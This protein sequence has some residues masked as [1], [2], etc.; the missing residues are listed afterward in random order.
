MSGSYRFNHAENSWYNV[1]KLHLPDHDY[2]NKANS[3]YSQSDPGVK[4]GERKDGMVSGGL[5]YYDNATYSGPHTNKGSFAR[6][7]DEHSD[8]TYRKKRSR[9]LLA[10]IIIVLL[11]VIGIAVFL[12]IYFGIM[13]KPDTV[14]K[15]SQYEKGKFQTSM[16]INKPYD[17]AY[18]NQNSQQ[19]KDMKA[20][21]EGQLASMYQGSALKNDFQGVTVTGLSQGSIVADYIITLNP[22]TVQTVST[23]QQATEQSVQQIKADSSSS[24]DLMKAVDQVTVTVVVVSQTTTTTTPTTT[25][26]KATTTL[27]VTTEGAQPTTTTIKAP[28]TTT[29]KA[30]T[31]E[32]LT[33]EDAQPSM[34]TTKAPTTTT[35]KTTTTEVL[36]TEGD[37]PST[38]TSKTPTTTTTEATTEEV[39]TTEDNKIPMTTT[40]IT[41]TTGTTK[42]AITEAETTKQIT[43]QQSTQS[44]VTEAKKTTQSVVTQEQT[45][46]ENL[47]TQEHTTAENIITQD[48]TTTQYVVT[49][50][51]TTAE[52]VITQD[53]TTTQYVV[54]PEQTTAENVITQDKTTTQY[55]VTPEQTTA[56]NV[57]TQDKTTTQYVVTPEQTTAENVITQD[58][59]TT[60][61]VVTPEQTTAENVITQDKTTTQYVV[62]PEQTTAENVITQDKT[63]TQY[64]VTPEQTTAENVI[65]QDKTTTQYVVTPEQTTAENVITQDKTTTQYVVTPEQTT[66]ENV[67][68]QDKTTAEFVVS[69]EQTTSQIE[70]T[71][72]PPSDVPSVSLSKVSY[73]VASGS[74]TLECSV[75]STLSVTNVFWQRQVLGDIETIN[76]QTNITK[77]TGSSTS[78]PSLTILNALPSDEG[79][80]VCFASSSG[81]Q[82]HSGITKL[83]VT[84]VG[85]PCTDSSLLLSPSLACV[86]ASSGDLARNGITAEEKCSILMGTILSC[87]INK[88]KTD[89]S[90][91]ICTE[92]QRH[93]IIVDNRESIG[94]MINVDP[95][96]CLPTSSCTDIKA[97][98][99]YIPVICESQINSLRSLGSCGN[100]SDALKCYYY[101]VGTDKCDMTQYMNTVST[102]YTKWI[103]DIKKPEPNTCNVDM[104]WIDSGSKVSLCSDP[105]AVHLIVNMYC[106]NDLKEFISASQDDKC[107]K[108]SNLVVCIEQQLK[109]VLK[110]PC[111]IESIYQLISMYQTQVIGLSNQPSILDCHIVMTT[112]TDEG[113]TMEAMTTMD[114][115]TT[116]ATIVVVEGEFEANMKVNKTWDAKFEDKNSTE[117]KELTEK[118]RNQT[119]ALYNYKNSSVEVEDIVILEVSKGSIVFVILIILKKDSPNL[120]NWTSEKLFQETASII[121][122]VKNDPEVDNLDFVKTINT[123]EISVKEVTVVLTECD[124][125]TYIKRIIHNSCGAALRR[126]TQV[127]DSQDRCRIFLQTIGC[128]VFHAQQCSVEKVTKTMTT[129]FQDIVSGV[130]TVTGFDPRSCYASVDTVV[131]PTMMPITSPVRPCVHPDVLSYILNFDCHYDAIPTDIEQGASMTEKCRF[132]W[133]SSAC[134]YRMSRMNPLLQSAGTC[135]YSDIT[136]VLQQ[137]ASQMYRVKPNNS[138]P[139]DC[140]SYNRDQDKCSS[141]LYESEMYQDFDDCLYNVMKARFDTALD[142]ANLTCVLYEEA[143]ECVFR[144]YKWKGLD[145]CVKSQFESDLIWMINMRAAQWSQMMGMNIEEPE[146]THKCISN[147][148]SGPDF[149]HS[150]CGD[151]RGLILSR[152]ECISEILMSQPS[153]SVCRTFQDRYIPC[154]MEKLSDHFNCTND[155]IKR[156][157]LEENHLITKLSRGKVDLSS[158]MSMNGTDICTS[159]K[160]EVVNFEDC[161]MAVYGFI[162]KT[163]STEVLCSGYNVFLNCLSIK[164]G[165]KTGMMCKKSS[166]KTWLPVY[167]SAF[168][169]VTETNIGACNVPDDNVNYCNNVKEVETMAMVSGCTAFS[170]YLIH[171]S[172]QVWTPYIRCIAKMFPACKTDQI[173]NTLLNS[174][175]IHGHVPQGYDVMKSCFPP[176]D[177]TSSKFEITVTLDLPWKAE[178]A[179]KNS[180]EYA[181]FTM[182][183]E[184]QVRGLN[185]EYSDVIE[186]I[187][188]ID[189][190]SGSVVVVIEMKYYVPIKVSDISSG[191]AQMIMAANRDPSS[192]FDLI[193]T[194]DPYSI[195]IEPKGDDTPVTGVCGSYNG[196]VMNSTLCAAAVYGFVNNTN[197]DQ[198]LLC[199]AYNIYLNC[200]HLTMEKETGKDCKRS[201]LDTWMPAA[202]PY[203]LNIPDSQFRSCDVDDDDVFSCGNLQLLEKMALNSACAAYVQYLQSPS[204]SLVWTPYLKCIADIFPSCTINGV[205]QT[206]MTSANFRGLVPQG[207]DL[208][209][210]CLPDESSSMF[211]ITIKFDIPWKPEYSNTDSIEFTDLETRLV[212]QIMTAAGNNSAATDYLKV[213]ELREG[214][215][216]A[217]FLIKYYYLLK[218][219]DIKSGTVQMILG[220]RSDPSS[221]LDLVKVADPDSVIVVSKAD[222]T[223]G[224]D[225]VCKIYNM[226]VMSVQTCIMALYGFMNKTNIDQDIFCRSYD[227]YLDC[228]HQTVEKNTDKKCARTSLNGWMPAILPSFLPNIRQSQIRSCNVNDE[229]LDSCHNTELIETMAMNSAC[230]TGYGPSLQYPFCQIWLQFINCTAM[231]FPSCTIRDVAETLVKSNFTNHIPQGFDIL[232][233]LQDDTTD[234]EDVCKVL[235]VEVMSVQTCIMALYGFMNTTNIDQGIFCRSY[236]IYLD[237]IHHTVEESTDKKCARTSL[238]GWMPAILPSYLPNI[239]QSQIRSCNVNDE[240]LDSCHNTELIETMAM[241]SA[242]FTGFGPS[243]Q[244]PFCQIWLPFINC[245]AMSFP[246]C[247]IRDVAE[248]LVKS[249]FT[250]NIPQGFDILACVPVERSN[251]FEITIKY[252]ITWM[253]AYAN[254]ASTEA[255]ALGTRLV[256]EIITYSGNTSAYFESLKVIELRE[257]SVIAVF[258]LK[259][260]N[261]VQLRTSEVK[262]G[263]EQMIL[264]VRGD[265]KTQFDLLKVADPDSVIVKSK[266]DKN[267]TTDVCAVISENIVFPDACGIVWLS[268]YNKTNIDQDFLCSIYE[269]YL[270]CI[271]SA[272]EEK[273]GKEC[274]RTSLASWIPNTILA[275]LPNIKDT[276]LRACSISNDKDICNDP[277]TLEVAAVNTTCSIAIF[278]FHFTPKISCRNVTDYF[279]CLGGFLPQCDRTDMVKKIV[280]LPVFKA[281]VPDHFEALHCYGGG[282]DVCLNY[283]NYMLVQDEEDCTEA[284]GQDGQQDPFGL[285]CKK[286]NVYLSCV[287]T[288]IKESHQCEKFSLH[289]WLPGYID[290]RYNISGADR[291]NVTNEN[292]CNDIHTIELMI[293][294][295]KC[296]YYLD[297]MASYPSCLNARMFLECMGG[298]FPGCDEYMFAQTMVNSIIKNRI[299]QTFNPMACFG[300]SGPSKFV[301]EVKIN[302]TWDEDLSSAETSKYR[303]LKS[304]IEQ[305]ARM[306]FSNK[307]LFLKDHI[308][309]ID[310]LSFKPG[311]IIVEFAVIIKMNSDYYKTLQLEDFRQELLR[312][313]KELKMNPPTAPNYFTSVDVDSINITGSDDGHP[314]VSTP[315]TTTLAPDCNSLTYISSIVD[316]HCESAKSRLARVDKDRKC[317]VLLDMIGC[318]LF[319]THICNKEQ[320]V[321][322]MSRDSWSMIGQNIS[323]FDPISC[324]GPGNEVVLPTIVP[325]NVTMMP[326]V[327]PDVVH[328]ILNYDCYYY[329]LQKQMQGDDKLDS[330]RMYW[331]SSACLYG[332]LQT[333]KDQLGHCSLEEV[334]GVLTKYEDELFKVSPD[335][336]TMSECLGLYKSADKCSRAMY[337]ED[338]FILFQTCYGTAVANRM[339][340]A[341]GIMDLS[342]YPCL[343][344]QEMSEC[345]YR[346]I[347]EHQLCLANETEVMEDHMIWLTNGLNDIMSIAMG[348]PL[349]ERKTVEK[350]IAN[351]TK[352]PDFG[353]DLCDDGA[354]LIMSEITCL[355]YINDPVCNSLGSAYIPCLSN[356]LSRKRIFC[357][358]ERIWRSLSTVGDL[359]GK[360][361]QG[362]VD[363]SSCNRD[364]GSKQGTC[365]AVGN[366][367]VGT[368]VEECSRDYNCTGDQKCCS[369]GCGHVCMDPDS[370]KDDDGRFNIT[371][372]FDLDWKPEYGGENSTFRTTLTN[373][374]NKIIASSELKTYLKY[375]RVVVLRPGSIIAGCEA[376]FYMDITEQKLEMTLKTRIEE[377]QGDPEYTIL[378]KWSDLSVETLPGDTGNKQGTCPAVGNHTVATCVEECSGDYYCTGDQKCCSNG[379]GHVCMDPDSKKDDDSRFNIT[380]RF[381]LDWKPEYGGENSTFRTTLTN[382]LNKIIAS[383]ELKTYLKYIRVVV[384]R[385]GS[386]I[387]GCEAEFYM[388]IT[389]QKLEMTLKTRIE[390]IQGDPEYTILQKWSDLSVETLPGDT[391]NKQGTC[392]AV[393]NHTVGTCVEECSGDYY[394]TGDQKCCSNGCGHVCMD[395]D[396]NYNPSYEFEITI[397]FGIPWDAEYTDKASGKYQNLTREILKQM[398]IASGNFSSYI[399]SMKITDLRQ[400]SVYVVFEVKYYIQLTASDIR[401]GML[402]FVTAARMDPK[403]ELDLIKAVDTDH[404]YVKIITDVT[405]PP[406]TTPAPD[407][408]SM[409]YISSILDSKCDSAKSQLRLVDKDRKCRV[410]LDMIGC[411]LFQTGICN[412]EQIVST[413]SRDSWSMIGQNISVFDPI[414]CFGPGKEVV[415]PTI[416]PLN[417][418][419]MPCVNPDV[420]HYILN[421]DCYYYGLQKQMQGEDK[422]DSCRMYWYSSACLYGTLQTNKDKLGQCSLEEVNGVLTKYEDEL[423][424]VSPDNVT[425]SECLGLYK[426]ADKCTRAMYSE[427]VFTIVQT[428]YGTAV[429]NRISAAYGIMD[430]SDYPCLIYQEMSECLYRPIKEHKLCLANETEVM[431]DHMIWLTNGLNDIMTIAMGS[432]LNERKTVQTCMANV[433]KT[434]DFGQDLCDDGAG[435]IM[436]EITCLYSIGDQI[437]NS[438]ESS[439]I[440]CLT[441]GLSRKRIFC[442]A[443]RIWHSLTAVSDLFGKL[444]YGKVDITSCNRDTSDKQGNC[445][446]IGNNTVGIC[447]EECSRDYNCTGNQKCCSNGCGHVCMDP[448]SKKDDSS[449]FN[450]T[451]RFNLDWMPEYRE[452]NS[453]FRSTLTN[454]L[455]KIVDSSELKA[456]L[457][458]IRVVVLRPGS[459]I[460]ECEAEIDMDITEQKLEMTLKTRIE[461]IQGDP[462]YTLLQKWSDLSVESLPES[463]DACSDMTKIGREL[464]L[465]SSYLNYIQHKDNTTNCGLYNYFM[466]CVISSVTANRQKCTRD[467]LEG[468]MQTVFESFGLSDLMTLLSCPGQGSVYY[469]ADLE[470]MKTVIRSHFSDTR[471]HDPQYSA[472]KQA[473]KQFIFD[474]FKRFGLDTEYHTFN[475]TA[476]SSTA[477][478]QSVIGVLKGTRFGTA[479]D[480]ISGLGAHYDTVNTSKGVDDN[481]SG[482]AAMLEVVRQITNI[483]NSGYKSKNTIIFVSFDLEE[484]GGLSGSRNFLQDWITPWLIKNYG[485]IPTKLLGVIIL[486]TIMEYNTSSQSQV[487]PLGA[488]DQFQQYFPSAVESILSDDARGDFISLIYRQPTDD[489]VLAETFGSS[490]AAAGRS[491]FEIE[492]FPLPFG[493]LSSIPQENLALMYQFLRSDHYNFWGANLPAIFLTDSAN[494]RGDMIQCYHNPCDDLDTMLTDENVNFMGKTA[495]TVT[496]TIHRLSE[497]FTTDICEDSMLMELIVNQSCNSYLQGFQNQSSCQALSSIVDRCLSPL[498][499]GVTCDRN[500]MLSHVVTMVMVAKMLPVGFDISTCGA[501]N[502]SNN[503]NQ[504]IPDMCLGQWGSCES[505]QDCHMVTWSYNPNTQMISFNVTAAIYPDQWLGV[506]FNGQKTMAGSDALVGWITPQSTVTVTDRNNPSYYG[507][508][509]DTTQNVENAAW[510]R[511]NGI[512]SL[513]FQRHRDTKDS[514]DFIFSEDNCAYFIY[515]MGGRYNENDKSINKHSKTPTFSLKQHCFPCAD[516]CTSKELFRKMGNTECRSQV[517]SFR[518]SDDLPTFCGKLQRIT[519]CLQT[520]LPT[521]GC[522]STIKDSTYPVLLTLLSELVRFDTLSKAISCSSAA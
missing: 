371:I 52:N 387:A 1:H 284:I 188:V 382:E 30:T 476:V 85:N 60:Q 100:F 266:T 210:S 153:D 333:N 488:M 389:E 461:E 250:S 187:K 147:S 43:Q 184:E 347:K 233:C 280:E 436:S 406:T 99:Y 116:T 128:V 126:L 137:H 304:T 306:L 225:D 278:Y 423:F 517:D 356:G 404:I 452:E 215:V 386:I 409:T 50:E 413:M 441:N 503:A 414:S 17:A 385:P 475:D 193:K 504:S 262:S 453:T 451:I 118:F 35:T 131:L 185:Q 103:E 481:G 495:D 37:Q 338:V 396:S 499:P 339:S 251:L 275:F 123:E 415:L 209:T 459:I 10:I 263:T 68:T 34:T 350:C 428:C 56:E 144:Y 18:A 258:Q 40:T 273:T 358:A 393:G 450:I 108:A 474:E 205:A 217:V 509:L 89:Y 319:H 357:S 216:I 232:T 64:V 489:R 390:E 242:C 418:T 98:T 398:T 51:Q 473:A 401:S 298:L 486:D 4:N 444:T 231:T 426:S 268:V 297:V 16:K 36:T 383:S 519:E 352:T 237:C 245:T 296:G 290:R 343:I 159:Y 345:L 87:I 113:T 344:Y 69:Q 353:Q 102:N 222:D 249:N 388:D 58:K 142:T 149:G 178:Y 90:G 516:V 373:E 437:C 285:L 410:L 364:T 521:H 318:V 293:N 214:S 24:S 33:T 492:S 370:K 190:R 482:V 5:A 11:L 259:Y 354:G 496:A 368:C 112:P 485:S 424:K 422:L 243:L 260:Y 75:T 483:N 66:A 59:T 228:I 109:A 332:T 172:C 247:S 430:L 472:Y 375:I 130:G 374:L 506:G 277:K 200:L 224:S 180:A 445:P 44:V 234:S 329:G 286:Y 420:V 501:S 416:V 177:K 67:I 508:F 240:D 12:G 223:T 165:E 355:F 71:T 198:D 3:W 439:Y 155:V 468:I 95:M 335:N 169:T 384:L 477:T 312:A 83:S 256:Q 301:A 325:L 457:K 294:T 238:N 176:P 443:E 376:E 158:C 505:Q 121:E 303:Q 141:F 63:T 189:V 79:S 349:E 213:L 97:I 81:G 173:A 305:Q 469:R 19:Y 253:P 265:P 182:K 462:E 334:N 369:N 106:P 132:Y 464:Q 206:L 105:D 136:S 76:S 302:A 226:E 402:G 104:D 328:Y 49:P 9:C 512:E 114:P 252:N 55:V 140:Y 511:L 400:G 270:G 146:I 346:P 362:R 162:N 248:T 295:T 520:N 39:L 203:M 204:C 311:S 465:C 507:S 429:A 22:N 197:V 201:T 331:Y 310:V 148:T 279:D 14:S 221:Q 181:N 317:S 321:S 101:H 65:T 70:A 191:T 399:A 395:P 272:Q 490:W 491:E 478:F 120:R 194:G 493:D 207:L 145:S 283:T 498:M 288:N 115:Q 156:S 378:Q 391:G 403:S 88:I 227:I 239:P 195:I 425:M 440:P 2:T 72:M 257:G 241:N 412:K 171:P 246:S 166:L 510:D 23:V 471:H 366:H 421:Y 379:C 460:A 6:G 27:D 359:F 348:S 431:E 261:V 323:V 432:P 341:Y 299:P 274:K 139:S 29:T 218:T 322:T 26:T 175:T 91:R 518:E 467:S 502:H 337:R 199:S 289:T 46:A 154:I 513:T 125:N 456:Y 500:R 219:S 21:L 161:S 61:Y 192:Q 392:P 48:K 235:N 8:D 522:S 110:A 313:I 324:F 143:T 411:V 28:T 449:R 446:P 7:S 96:S 127:Q 326:C 515:P 152:T 82:G 62:T 342:D 122:A 229:D 380:I 365:P 448:D 15:E 124:K 25:T 514:T 458:Y 497:P 13:D 309:S 92:E 73:S 276:Q 86:A 360:L 442:S 20:K 230:F 167:L 117:Y 427:D 466:N 57:I 150:I 196:R 367:T 42:L 211:E 484:Y 447:V 405:P 38:T 307:V 377:I 455:N 135:T 74:V 107:M 168:T 31:A 316:S 463:E 292:Y 163:V 363:I 408:N 80:Y 327:H 480:L 340:A 170:K 361:T 264:Q 138:T 267:Q 494:F 397:K 164:N 32:V 54:T 179:D 244:Y 419:M 282:G 487:F 351:V 330:C 254:L 202:L 407:C 255:M 53:K 281:V 94:S 157:I 84:G 208:I 45:T 186:Y 47:V 271:Q 381:D 434:P 269:I 291:C 129:H 314:E 315:S 454:E 119:L 174:S 78:N 470:Y 41:P 372:R 479:D 394:C 151:G 320:I 435:L 133:Q 160:P 236:T 183:V 287:T 93:N 134:V 77:Y 300:V 433:T 336:V 220:V 308:E 417:V 438:L 212:N 111:T